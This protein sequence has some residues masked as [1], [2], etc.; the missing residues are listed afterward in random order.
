MTAHHLDDIAADALLNGERWRI[1]KAAHHV[2]ELPGLYAIYGN[3]TAW[4]DLE[5]EP[6]LHRPL[7]V[8]KTEESL[9]KRDLDD[10]FVAGPTGKA[11][12]G[13]STV[14]R[15]FA[16]LLR[17]QLDL[18]AVPRNLD[19]PGHFNKYGLSQGGDERL[20][21]WMHSHLELAVW[22]KPDGSAER[23][24]DVE[25]AVIKR[26]APPINIQKNPRKLGRLSR[27]R[28]EMKIEA[29]QWRP[30]HR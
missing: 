16:A 9:V 5:L 23:L 13:G 4:L 21:E 11:R 27:A 20:T 26:F 7:Y 24:V 29:Q 25:T 2:L 30:E 8:G 18:H 17:D 22:F 28:S 12:T 19:N 1:L 15:S 6:E 14:R 10:H 3:A